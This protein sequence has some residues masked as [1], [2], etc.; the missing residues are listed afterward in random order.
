MLRLVINEI[1]DRTRCLD[2][3]MRLPSRAM[4]EVEKQAVNSATTECLR[5]RNVTDLIITIL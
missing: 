3:R 5:F 1:D 2:A 4:S